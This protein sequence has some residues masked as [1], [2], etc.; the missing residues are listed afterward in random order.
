MSITKDQ[1]H[2]EKTQISDMS[3]ESEPVF[4]VFSLA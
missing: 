4:L 1:K 3:F 2:K